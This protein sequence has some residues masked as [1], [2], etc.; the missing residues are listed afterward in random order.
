MLRK[1]QNIGN[2]PAVWHFLVDVE[3][4]VNRL[5]KRLDEISDPKA[6]TVRQL[7]KKRIIV[8]RALQY[9]SENGLEPRRPA[10][11]SAEDQPG[12][13]RGARFLPQFPR[14]K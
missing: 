12:E 14:G 3:M 8:K 4:R 6:L 10:E 9:M 1:A 11:A 13:K 5:H 7:A 2:D